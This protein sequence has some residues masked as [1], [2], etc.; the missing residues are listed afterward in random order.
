M[1]KTYILQMTDKA[2]VF[3]KANNSVLKNGGTLIRAN[4][5]KVVDLHTLFL[6]VSA[7]K[8]NLVI[9]EDELKDLGYLIDIEDDSKFILI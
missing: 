4:F 2:G 8:E 5:N 7:S 6:E 1:K 9:I 3:L